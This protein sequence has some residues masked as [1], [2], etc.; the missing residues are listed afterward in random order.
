MRFPKIKDIASRTVV[1]VDMTSSISDAIDLMLK[2]EHRSV[3]VIDRNEFYLFTVVDVLL[4]Q[5]SNIPLTKS[6]K[7]IPLAK[8]QTIDKDKSVLDTLE[9][10]NNNIENICVLN[11][12]KTLYGIITHTDIT[13]NIDPSTLMEN[14]RLENFLKM[15][16]R[17]KWVTKDQITIKI[18]QDMINNSF[19]N[20][21]VV[22]D[23]KPIGILTTK[24]V[25][26]LIKEQS[27]LRISIENYMSS[28]VETI[29]KSASIKDALNFIKEKKYKRAIVVNNRE[30]LV[31]VISQ[32][33]L[34]SLTYSGWAML[35]KEYHAE[36]NE[37]NSVLQSQNKEF[38]TMASTDSLTGLY[39]RHKFAQL[40]LNAYNSMVQ[41]HNSMSLIMLDLDFFKRINDRYGHNQGDKALIQLSHI[42]LKTL[43]NIDIV[44][45]W[46]GE[47]FIALLPTADLGQAILLAGKLQK[48]IQEQ[49][50]D[51]IGKI[52]AS[53]GV[54]Q[55][56]EGESMENAVVRA[57]RAL[58]LA[59]ESGRNCVRSELDISPN[60]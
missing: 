21:I 48:Q 53:F 13:S 42:L 38:E 50:I 6:L 35:M 45:R 44:C 19:D 60:S 26:R 7:E 34:I 47:E 32:K 22:E 51:I 39:N 41:R 11:Q 54:A 52:T 25:M 55:I 57:D 9:F 31:G 2:S 14:F 17:M 18:L 30:K 49:E 3:V 4:V 24:D 12:D 15:G 56:R 20:V 5:S 23:L 36:L 33:E 28:P 1:S 40:Y 8:I 29:N 37:I 10:L 27:N 16:R 46:G 43:R 59:K 58:Y